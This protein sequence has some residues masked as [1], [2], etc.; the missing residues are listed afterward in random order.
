MLYCH[1]IK[2]K[3]KGAL[4]LGSERFCRG[5]ETLNMTEDGKGNIN[6]HN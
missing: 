3:E 6:Q 2:C 5:R 4:G 1:D